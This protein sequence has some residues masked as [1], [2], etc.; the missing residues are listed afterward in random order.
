[1]PVAVGFPSYLWTC[2][3][4]APT[5]CS[6]DPRSRKIKNFCHP[7]STIEFN[8]DLDWDYS[9]CISPDVGKMALGVRLLQAYKTGTPPSS[10]RVPVGRLNIYTQTSGAV[11]D[12]STRPKNMHAP[13]RMATQSGSD[14]V[15]ISIF[16]QMLGQMETIRCFYRVKK[17]SVRREICSHY[18]KRSAPDGVAMSIINCM[19]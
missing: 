8:D 14:G 2:L 3:L 19:T 10:A 13:S 9:E 12:K 6:R 16:V 18:A 1:M 11:E 5:E 7:S 4:L 15:N 17:W